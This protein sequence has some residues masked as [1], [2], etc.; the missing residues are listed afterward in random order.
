MQ[1]L[2]QTLH[3]TCALE[4]EEAP[5]VVS[6]TYPS[7]HKRQKG[8]RQAR[9]RWRSTHQEDYQT[10]QDGVAD[11]KKTRPPQALNTDLDKRLEEHGSRPLGLTD[12]FTH[13][14]Q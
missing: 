8:V 10:I 7:K 11:L 3:M 14:H 4:Q 13:T 5:K 12:P 6:G 1:T 9:Q 2:K